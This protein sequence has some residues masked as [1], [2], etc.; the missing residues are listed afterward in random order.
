MT[1]AV[2]A[3]PTTPRDYARVRTLEAQPAALPITRLL[4]MCEAAGRREQHGEPSAPF[5]NYC[6]GHSRSP[7]RVLGKLA[8]PDGRFSAG[9]HVCTCACHTDTTGSQ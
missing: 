8:D 2:A 1:T 4:Y 9:F 6:L 7:I 5:H 3:R